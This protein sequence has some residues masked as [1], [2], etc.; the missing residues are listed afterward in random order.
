MAIGAPTAA[1]WMLGCAATRLGAT[2]AQ[3]AVGQ[4]KAA[5]GSSVYTNECA[6]CHG[7]R[8]EG[9]AG[10][11]E[12]MGPGALPEFPKDLGNGNQA[13]TDPQ[14]LQIQQQTR[15]QG[16]PWRDPFRT[17]QDLYGFVKVHLPKAR[18]AVMKN[19][20][21]WAVVTFILAVQGA[22]VPPNGITADNAASI[23]VPH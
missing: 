22:N 3:L 16:A 21:Y 18:A 23:P 11:S 1:L 14:Q 4:N 2:D 17:A 10:T 7:P 5:T 6:R 15:P 9:L 8:G 20:D 12:V 19:D 13:V